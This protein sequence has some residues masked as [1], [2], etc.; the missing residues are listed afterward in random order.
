VF[1]GRCYFVFF[2]LLF[3]NTCLVHYDLT[4]NLGV[5]AEWR[6]YQDVGGGT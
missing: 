2:P 1:P 3:R 6:K 5:R 4:R